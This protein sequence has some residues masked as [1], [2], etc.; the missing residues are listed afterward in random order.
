M[1]KFRL[2][3][4]ILPY[5][6]WHSLIF[7]TTSIYYFDLNIF[8][9]QKSIKSLFLFHKVN[10]ACWVREVETRPGLGLERDELPWQLCISKG[11]KL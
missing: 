10:F 4:I 9:Y 3:T 5:G 7:I 1:G 11:N 2:G 6:F 8:N